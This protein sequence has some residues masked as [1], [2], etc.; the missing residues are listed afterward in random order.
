MY[1]TLPCLLSFAEEVALRTGQATNADVL[2]SAAWAAARAQESDSGSANGVGK[3]T[4][5]MDALPQ[6]FRS[7]QRAPAELALQHPC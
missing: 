4:S 5:L 6:R 3:L 1:P 2:D 7:R